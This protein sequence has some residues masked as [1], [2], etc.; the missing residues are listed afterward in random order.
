MKKMNI[1]VCPNAAINRPAP[2]SGWAN[3]ASCG[4]GTSILVD[5]AKRDRVIWP[6]DMGVSTAVAFATTGD[7]LSAQNSLETLYAHQQKDGMLP[8]VAM[9][10]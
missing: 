8:C 2:P 5:G 6:G 3:N 4:S 1:V 7:T 10:C 9:S